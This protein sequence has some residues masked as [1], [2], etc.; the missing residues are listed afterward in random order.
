MKW[1]RNKTGKKNYWDTLKIWK[2]KKK[3]KRSLPQLEKKTQDEVSP[4]YVDAQMFWQ[5]EEDII[6]HEYCGRVRDI[7]N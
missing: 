4:F 7:S 1:K 5:A 2:V 6:K 3:S